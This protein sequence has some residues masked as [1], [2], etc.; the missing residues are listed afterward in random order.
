MMSI[1]GAARSDA[2]NA[3]AA[4]AL[5]GTAAEIDSSDDDAIAPL[6]V[7]AVGVPIDDAAFVDDELSSKLLVEGTWLDA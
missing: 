5:L 1:R 7:A 4:A 2:P 6:A 3:A